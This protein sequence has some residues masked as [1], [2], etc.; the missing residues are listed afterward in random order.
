MQKLPLPDEHPNAVSAL[1]NRRADI[2]GRIVMHENEVAKLRAELV[3]LD[4]VMRMFDPATNPDDLPALRRWP[5]KT[6]WFAR[7]EISQRVYEAIRTG[8]PLTPTRLAD[9]AITA[10]RIEAPD[11][12]TRRDIIARFSNMLYTLARR[13]DLVKIGHGPGAH[14]KVAPKEPDLI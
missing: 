13:G 3:H 5:Y 2:A 9:E 12:A 10:K 6:E 14:W 7:G 11:R 8:A 1:R 4:A